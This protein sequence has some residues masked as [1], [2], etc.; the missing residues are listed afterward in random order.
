MNILVFQNIRF[1]ILGEEVLVKNGISVTIR[2][3]PNQISS[4]C[5]MCIEVGNDDLD[6][7]K[8]LLDDCAITFQLVKI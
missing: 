3:V 5:G 4:E 1:V 6:A 2:P 8:K 7:V